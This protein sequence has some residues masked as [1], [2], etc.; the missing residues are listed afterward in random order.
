MTINIELKEAKLLFEA[1]ALRKA[2]IQRDALYGAYVILFDR[3]KGNES[4]R[5][6]YRSQRNKEPK[7]F[8]NIDIIQ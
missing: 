8:R 7:V 5:T 3:I 4:I 6:V 2:Y 1:G